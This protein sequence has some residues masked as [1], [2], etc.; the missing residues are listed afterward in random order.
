M[1]VTRHPSPLQ[2]VSKRASSDST[3]PNEYRSTITEG[4][5]DR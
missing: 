3:S 2:R 5:V 1:Q 4:R